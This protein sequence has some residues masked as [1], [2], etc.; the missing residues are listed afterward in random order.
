MTA[1]T[2]EAERVR[3]PEHIDDLDDVKAWIAHHDGR[4]GALWDAQHEWN[5]KVERRLDGTMTRDSYSLS[6]KSHDDSL[7]RLT[8]SVAQTDRRITALERRVMWLTGFAAGAGAI[9]GEFLPRL[10]GG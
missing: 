6:M 3:M 5:R 7:M 4:I 8:S 9:V 1:A 2:L 10:F